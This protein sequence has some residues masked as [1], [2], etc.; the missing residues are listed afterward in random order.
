MKQSSR[1]YSQNKEFFLLSASCLL[2]ISISDIWEAPALIQKGVN[3]ASQPH[4]LTQMDPILDYLSPPKA[5]GEGNGATVSSQIMG[6]EPVAAQ[7]MTDGGECVKT[8]EEHDI[9][10]PPHTMSTSCS[11]VPLNNKHALH[12]VT[13]VI[14]FI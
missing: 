7:V 10:D 5:C 9:T 14:A 6:W 4:C 1:R 2:C 13:A 8:W 3:S 11:T 12:I